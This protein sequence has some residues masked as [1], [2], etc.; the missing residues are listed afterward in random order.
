MKQA[1]HVLLERT[2]LHPSVDQR[3]PRPKLVDAG[4][5]VF[6]DAAEAEPRPEHGAG[7][8]RRVHDALATQFEVIG[9]R[10]IASRSQSRCT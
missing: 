1:V 6:G 7:R 2:A 9:A 8:L 10:R 4:A 3:F 5:P